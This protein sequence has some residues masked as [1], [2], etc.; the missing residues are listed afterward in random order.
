MFPSQVSINPPRGPGRRPEIRV[1]IDVSST[2]VDKSFAKVDKSFAGVDKS[3]AGVD[4]SFTGV[5][6]SFTG[7]DKSFMFLAQGAYPRPW[8][9]ENLRKYQC[10]SLR[11]LAIL[12]GP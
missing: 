7:V 1:N 5:N 10:P 11:T 12:D 2:R 9:T 4:K 3:F 6:K 8:G